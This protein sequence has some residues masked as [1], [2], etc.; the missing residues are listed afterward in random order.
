MGGFEAVPGL[1]VETCR[2]LVAFLLLSMDSPKLLRL[3]LPGQLESINGSLIGT[4]LE[5][6]EE[7]IED[8]GETR[9]FSSATAELLVNRWL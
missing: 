7:A 9:L 1:G 5:A 6:T 2:V 3:G 4:L 8:G